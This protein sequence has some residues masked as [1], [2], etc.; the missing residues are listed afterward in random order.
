MVRVFRKPDN[1]VSILITPEGSTESL[2]REMLR[3]RV[4]KTLPYT[5]MHPSQLPTQRDKRY[6]WRI[7]AAGAV[8]V[9]NTVVKPA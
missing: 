5:D 6:A 2:D 8:K 4:L 7:D 3:N 9:D 1:S